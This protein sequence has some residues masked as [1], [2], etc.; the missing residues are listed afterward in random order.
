[1][2]ELRLPRQSNIPHNLRMLRQLFAL[3]VASMG[4]INGLTILLPARPGR[5]ALLTILVNL[6]APFAP[7]IWPFV[8]VG[9]TLSLILGFFPYSVR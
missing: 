8:S 3:T 2:L 6:L 9:R 1:M 5:L 7:S 4:L